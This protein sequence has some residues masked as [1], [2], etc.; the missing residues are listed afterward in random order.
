MRRSTIIMLSTVTIL[1]SCAYQPVSYK[2]DISPIISTNCSECHTAPNGYGYQKTGLEMHSYDVLMKGT[3]YGPV[4]IAGDSRRSIL[5]KLL[6]G[7]AGN[8]QNILHEN[9]KKNISEKD[10]KTFRDWVDGGALNN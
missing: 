10:V 2:D 1:C 9:D 5:N 6:E 8:L 4:V 7:R 3:I